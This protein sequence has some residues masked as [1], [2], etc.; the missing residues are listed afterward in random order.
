MGAAEIVTTPFAAPDNSLTFTPPSIPCVLFPITNYG[1]KTDA[2]TLNTMAFRQAVAAAKAA[3][4]GVV[5]VPAGTWLTGA[6]QLESH[7]ELHVESGATVLFSANASDY[8]PPVLTRWE[9]LDVMNWSPFV[10]ALNAT[11]VAITGEGT[12]KGPGNSWG[13]GIANW[14]AGSIAEDARVY[15]LYVSA[16]NGSGLLSPIPS[17][18][19]SAVQNGLRPTFVE[20]NGCTNFLVDGI[21]LTGAIYWALHPL[22]SKN[23][24]IRHVSVDTTATSSNGDGTDPD[25][26][27]NCLIENVTYATSDDNIAIKSGLNEDGIAVAKPSHN[28]VIRNVT[29]TTGHGGVTIGSE[30]SG[31][32]NNVYATADTFNGVQYPLRIKTLSGRGGTIENLWYE[33]L[34]VGWTNNAIQMTTQYTSSTIPPHN[35][36]L[37]PALRN[38]AITGMMGTGSGPVY[39]ITGP[40]SNLS[41]KMVNLTGTGASTCTAATGISLMNV[42]LNGTAVTTLPGC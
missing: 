34:T 42:T 36:G 10:Y 19:M 21:T 14:K 3:G 5:D 7:I 35:A 11:N 24:I 41:L 16:L 9:G 2:A 12:L 1:A 31:G 40:L 38:I 4:G 30:M 39:G 23:V 27:T 25:S 17:P 18:P 26:C 6:I 32:V 37:V 22:Y 29:S 8:L 15:Q 20:C 13:G 28:I 33:N